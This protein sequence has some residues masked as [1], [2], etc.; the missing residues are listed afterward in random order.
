[1]LHFPLLALSLVIATL[2]GALFHFLWGRTL[3][4]LIIYWVAAVLGFA[5][6]QLLASAFSSPDLLIGELHL[7]ASSACA[8]F[9]MAF[10]RR[11]K[12]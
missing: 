8:W 3:R 10:A 5:I 2:F 1:M 12:S 4:D 9:F 11:L 6:G 7:V